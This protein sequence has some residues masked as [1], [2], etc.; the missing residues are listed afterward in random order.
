MVIFTAIRSVL[1]WDGVNGGYASLSIAHLGITD[2]FG[3]KR[4]LFVYT[5]CYFGICR[6]VGFP[7]M[8]VCPLVE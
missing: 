3:K 1:V 5:S 2:N 7:E 8:A 4:H 6:G